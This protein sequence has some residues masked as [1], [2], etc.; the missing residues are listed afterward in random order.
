LKL[1]RDELRA[2]RKQVVIMGPCGEGNRWQGYVFDEL[3]RKTGA[4]NSALRDFPDCGPDFT[5]AQYDQQVIRYYE[6]STQLSKSVNGGSDP[7]DAPL[8]ARMTRCGVD[9]IGLDF[10]ARGDPRLAAQ[11]WS[12]APGQPAAR[13]SCSIQRYDGRWVTRTCDRH[14]RAACRDT[15]GRWVVPR[16]SVTARAAPRAC[17]SARLVNGV[18]RTGFEAQQLRAAMA[19]GRAAAV[20]LGQRRRG[21]G[22]ARFE[23]RGCGPSI[24]EPRKRRPVSRG[25]ARLVVGLR[26]ACTGE[27][28]RGSRRIVVV[29]GLRRVRSRV[30]RLTRVPV[31][32][33]TRRL[34]V[35]FRYSGKARSAT[36]LLRR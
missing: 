8:A 32:A 34:K 21:G 6:D 30:G 14:R 7:I 18:P 2:A 29:G 17:A 27:R 13:G 20:W 19:R 10:L 3:P 1:T 25:V 11:V 5:R 16:A 24:V 9:L 36:V 26:F 31:A 33:G 35:R 28:L 15:T 12:W 4:D 23:K 22:W